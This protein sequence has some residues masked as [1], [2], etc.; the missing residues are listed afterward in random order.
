MASSR[1][2]TWFRGFGAIGTGSTSATL[3]NFLPVATPASGSTFLRYRT[4]LDLTVQQEVTGTGTGVNIGWWYDVTAV[5]GLYLTSGAATAPN[6]PFPLD[7]ATNDNWIMWQPLKHALVVYDIASPYLEH[8]WRLPETAEVRSQ[9]ICP[10]GQVSTLW[11]VWQVNDPSNTINNTTL[12]SQ[13]ARLGGQ[14]ACEAL[15]YNPI[16]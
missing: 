9:R 11:V 2:T 4:D 8:V 5:M 15:A 6:P 1:S 12:P 14:F 16:V 13:T 7:S 3:K 10:A